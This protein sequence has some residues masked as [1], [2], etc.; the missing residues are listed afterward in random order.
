MHQ[1]HK[2]PGGYGDSMTESAQWG[3]VSEVIMVEIE[4][5]AKKTGLKLIKCMFI[6]VNYIN[7]MCF[8]CNIW[9][10]NP[11]YC[12][13]RQLMPV[14]NEASA[15]SDREPWHNQR[16]IGP[17]RRTNISFLL[18][19]EKFTEE[20]LLLTPCHLKNN[21]YWKFRLKKKIWKNIYILSKYTNAVCRTGRARFNGVIM[22]DVIA[23]DKDDK[24]LHCLDLRQP[25]LA[26]LSQSINPWVVESLHRIRL[27]QQ[28][29]TLKLMHT[30]N[31]LFS[32]IFWFI[33]LFH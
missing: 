8:I 25:S 11:R 21:Y 32:M 28:N 7:T 16:D 22:S 14:G 10:K 2:L 29:T 30:E 13:P 3:R 31:V 26:I 9:R 24:Q 1:W 6:T 27:T 19:N 15:L 33:I 12:R 23:L 20:N 5:E 17:K 4:W 18:L